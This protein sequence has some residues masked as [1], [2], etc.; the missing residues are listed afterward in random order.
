MGLKAL[1]LNALLSNKLIHVTLGD[2]EGR[3]M[4]WPAVRLVP[5]GF[6]EAFPTQ[7][8]FSTSQ[9]AN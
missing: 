7:A 5:Q 4:V 6:V 2:D 8:D 9:L 1:G 3:G